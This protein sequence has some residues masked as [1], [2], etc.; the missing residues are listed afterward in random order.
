MPPRIGL[1]ALP[2]EIL[3]G[4]NYSFYGLFEELE[5]KAC[6][7]DNIDFF[8]LSDATGKMYKRKMDR[9]LLKDFKSRIPKKWGGET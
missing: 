2:K 1:G 3:V 5:K 9:K 4:Q 7:F 6:G 8:Y